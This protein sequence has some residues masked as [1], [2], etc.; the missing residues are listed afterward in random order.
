LQPG[1][2]CHYEFVLLVEEVEKGQQG[3]DRVVEIL[4]ECDGEI[5]RSWLTDRRKK[6]RSNLGLSEEP[7]EAD[8]VVATIDPNEAPSIQPDA[9]DIHTAPEAAEPANRTVT[10]LLITATDEQLVRFGK[11][12][13]DGATSPC[14]RIS[15]EI[16]A[17]AVLLIDAMAATLL[18]MSTIISSLGFSRCARIGLLSDPDGND[19][20]KSRIMA[21]YVRG[22]IELAAFNHWQT[23][24]DAAKLAGQILDGVHGRHVHLFATAE[25]DGWDSM[26]GDTNWQR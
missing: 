8:D 6:L 18:S 17:N 19:M 2:S 24:V 13:A 21:V 12:L 23:G 4:S 1:Y 26:V 3:L 11:E 14:V 20:T 5:S 7:E 25:T 10:A 22:N 15:G 16:D 9:S